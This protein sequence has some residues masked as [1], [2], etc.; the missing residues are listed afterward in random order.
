MLSEY[1]S[2]KQGKNEGRKRWFGD[3]FFDLIL[4]HDEEDSVVRFE[5]CYDKER[6]EHAISWSEAGGFSHLR[7]DDG[8]GEPGRYKMSP[9]LI[10]DGFFD[11]QKIA[12]K[13]LSHSKSIDQKISRFIYEKILE[14]PHP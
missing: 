5:L 9:I 14:Y 4:W 11:T 1:S 12:D 13:F 3:E 2:V 8:E 10:S 6:N 7:V